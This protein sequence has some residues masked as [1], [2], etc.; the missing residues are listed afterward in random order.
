MKIFHEFPDAKSY[1]ISIGFVNGALF[2]FH[3]TTQEVLFSQKKNNET[4]ADIQFSEESE[5]LYFSTFNQTIFK[6][7]LRSQQLGNR[8]FY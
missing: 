2:I 5:I 6:Y 4:I 1:F 8:I 3:L 7:D